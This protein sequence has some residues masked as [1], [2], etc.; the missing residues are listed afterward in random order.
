MS[1]IA[2]GVIV[3]PLTLLFLFGSA[4]GISRWLY[5]FFP[6]GRL[7]DTLYKPH[8]VVPTEPVSPLTRFICTVITAAIVVIIVWRVIRD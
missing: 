8:E 4:W 7:R 5:R 3:R 2:L 6:A 1:D